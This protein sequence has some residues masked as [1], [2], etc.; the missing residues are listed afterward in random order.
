MAVLKQPT[1]PSERRDV[2]SVYFPPIVDPLLR[3]VHFMSLNAVSKLKHETE[4]RD[5]LSIPSRHTK[6]M[7]RK[8]AT[9]GGFV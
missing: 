1:E 9:T 7:V 6:K 5:A 8:C 4:Q 2:V 3:Q